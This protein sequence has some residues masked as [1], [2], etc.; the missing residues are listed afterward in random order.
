MSPSPFPGA[1]GTAG[2]PI[3]SRRPGGAGGRR[4]R[5]DWGFGMGRWGNTGENTGE[6][7]GKSMRNS[8]LLGKTTM[9]CVFYDVTSSMAGPGF[10]GKT[11]NFLVRKLQLYVN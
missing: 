2:A 3:A 4:C 9:L 6:S 1:L 11:I 5:A 7:G 10:N 8:N